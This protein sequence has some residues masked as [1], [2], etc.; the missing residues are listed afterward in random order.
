[1]CGLFGMIGHNLTANEGACIH[2]EFFEALQANTKRGGEGWGVLL[3]N[4]YRT[5]PGTSS[6][7]EAEGIPF[8]GFFMNT[9]SHLTRVVLCHVRIPTGHHDADLRKVHPFMKGSLY[10]AHNGIIPDYKN[11]GRD[12]GSDVDSAYL[13]GLIS[14]LYEE[15]PDSLSNA[16]AKAVS[17]MGGQQACWLF[18][19][20]S[21]D[22]FVW[23]HMSPLYYGFGPESGQFLIS[24]VPTDCASKEFDE[25]VVWRFLKKDGYARIWSG[26]WFPVNSIYI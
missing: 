24:S 12:I 19:S 5:G 15:Q 11:T 1:M 21:Q 4:E 7:S 23:R 16:I 25:G 3:H 17:Q 6:F 2:Y 9:V 8:P 13:L 10:L 26:S 18:D 22:I 14:A 20:V